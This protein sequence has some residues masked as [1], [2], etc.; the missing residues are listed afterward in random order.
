M[1]NQQGMP[2]L[3]NVE[4]SGGAAMPQPGFDANVYSQGTY[5]QQTYGQPNAGQG[6]PVEGQG[7]FVA[8]SNGM[9]GAG[10]N[11]YGQA[12]ANEIPVGQPDYGQAANGETPYGQGTYGQPSYGQAPYGQQPGTPPKKKRNPLLITLAIVLPLLL[13]GGLIWGGLALFGKKGGAES[14]EA[15]VESF[16]TASASL[17]FM[18]VGNHMAPSEAEILVKPFEKLAMA[19]TN[20]DKVPNLSE[21][22]AAL[23]DAVDV[24]IEG[25][26]LAPTGGEGVVQFVTITDG[27][28]VVD[29]DEARFKDAVRDIVV[30]VAYDANLIMGQSESE[31][32]DS[33]QRT[34]DEMVD[35]MGSEFPIEKDLT[36]DGEVT[37]AAVE[38]DGQWYVSP[39][40]SWTTQMMTAMGAELDTDI[41]DPGATPAA[42][43]EEAG[44]QFLEAYSAGMSTGKVE[45]I[46]ATLTGPERLLLELFRSSQ[47]SN[48]GSGLDAKF[49]LSGGFKSEERDGATVIRP[50]NLR[51]ET[52]YSTVT[53]ND[54]CMTTEYTGYYSSGNTSKSCISDIP[55]ARALGLDQI[56]LVVKEEDGGWLVSPYGTIS[57]ALN[58]AVDS[59][60]KLREEGRLSELV[61]G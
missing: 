21:S 19:R 23:Q 29:G 14:P 22:L 7:A 52:N 5:G 61:E 41:Q 59:Y 27:T 18:E 17:D 4:N 36:S 3:P 15:A 34:A 8:A 54:D 26:E 44:M 38:E 6:T 25:L 50:D 51:V 12:P 55:Q 37:F 32:A 31:A 9:H 60:I 42:S 11:A 24:K 13:I 1:N 35:D 20:S 43:P 58:T 49:D 40:L 46:S 28:L 39:M 10:S 2:P 48:S 16:L 33:A 53:Y 57:L 56:G 30:G 47:P 45:E